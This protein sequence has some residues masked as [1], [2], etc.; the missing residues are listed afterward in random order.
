MLAGLTALYVLT[1]KVGLHFAFVHASA[2]AVW[3]PTGIALA[4]FLLF[5]PRV[6]L[7][8]A[9]GAFLVNVTTAGS[10]ATSVGIAAGNTLE[11]FLAATLVERF[12]NGRHAFERASD[13]FAFGL[14]V[15]PATLVSATI[16]VVSLAAGGYA[17]WPD[18]GS[19][20]ATWALGDL[21][22]ALIV[23]PLLLLWADRRA[24]PVL[25]HPLEAIGLLLSILLTGQVAFGGLLP[26]GF[27]RYPLV[28]LCFAP[29]VWAACR[30]GRRAAA[31]AVVLLSGIALYQ[32]R[33][34]LGPFALVPQAHALLIL[35]AFMATMS[36]VTLVIAA[37]VWVRDRESSMLQAI[38]DRIPV[39]ISVYEPNT[40]VVRLNPEFE[41][42]TGWTTD[43]ARQVDLMA[44]CY[45][46]PTYRA[47]VRAFMNGLSNDWHEIE[48]TTRD[49]QTVATSWTNVRLADDTRVGIGLDIRE[50]KRL[51]A[52]RERARAQAEAASRAKDE[53]FAILGHEL[54]N[55]LN[56]IAVW[57][58][59]V[60]TTGSLDP[61]ARQIIGKQVR[62]LTRLV[63]DL[64]DVNR[65]D[66]GKI[67]LRRSPVD[68]GV[69]TRRIVVTIAE[70]APDRQ[71][72]CDA[73]DDL[74]IQADETRLE[75]ILVNLLNNAVKFTPV[76][77]RI[78]VVATRDGDNALVRIEDTGVG[79][80]AE[81]LPRIFDLFVQGRTG[82][83]R[84]GAGLGIGLTLVKRLVDLHDGRVEVT[85]PGPSK[86]STFAVRF[87]LISPVRR[88]AAPEAA[89]PEFR[90]R[91]RILV[92]ED[93][94][95]TRRMLCR[96][97]AL[98][99]HEVY[100]ADDGVRGLEQ[101]LALGPE[102]VLLDIGLPGLDG[103][104]VAR[105]IR[106]AGRSD[107]MLIAV[108][109]YGQVEDRLRAKEAGFDSHITKPV[110]PTVLAAL[111][112]QQPL[113]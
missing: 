10:I 100:E 39:M 61:N 34:G 24:S 38:I 90:A 88:A 28:F 85:S 74:W 35:Q 99:G 11:G 112:T 104:Q 47:Q 57:M 2:T 53:F 79:I 95:D 29:L 65:L 73:L 64:L 107:M 41:R 5:G 105:H 22:G 106:A 102:V 21:T 17:A 63:D 45:P 71:I 16:G 49:G 67:E 42:L 37:L 86:G 27:E 33:Q 103:Y 26:H 4:A 1:G 30:F 60:E 69:T 14:A 48:M 75:Q 82:L 92:V 89:P 7:A 113:A 6:T 23:A 83:H 19:I 51:E 46:D 109:G 8:I 96:L 87:P 94:Q 80:P 81:L 12:A 52:E 110:N 54:R 9:A 13:I 66:T 43:A 55:P 77:G 32:T 108:T 59:V 70:G 36:L 50:Q 91:R 58:H 78:T 25:G 3:P 76:D 97:L 68:L 62:H 84:K 44:Q 18:F 93:D 40:K 72:V 101:A 111:L 56:A 98:S 15:V 31:T 20:A